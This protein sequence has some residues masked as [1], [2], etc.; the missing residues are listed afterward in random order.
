MPRAI[1]VTKLQ[2]INTETGNKAKFSTVASTDPAANTE[3]SIT[4]DRKS[5]V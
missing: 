1:E 2:N 5:V 4:V 3:C